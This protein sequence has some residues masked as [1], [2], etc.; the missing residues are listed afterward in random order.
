MVHSIPTMCPVCGAY[1]LTQ[2]GHASMLLAV[3]DTLV[4]KALEKLG[5]WLLSKDRGRFKVLGE[6]PY[7]L[8]HT[9]WKPDDALV[10]K[11]LK[12]AWDVVPPLLDIH[13]GCCDVTA[14]QV[15]EM[16]DSYV[17]DL[18]V[19]GYPHTIQDLFYRFET[20]LNLPVYLREPSD[21]HG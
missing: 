13:G 7:Y 17:H 18:A 19:A 3:C 11:A 1:S 16:L 12:G 9:I 20:R 15:V 2:E 5:R 6:R 14:Q 4:Y 8:A 10:S 21:A